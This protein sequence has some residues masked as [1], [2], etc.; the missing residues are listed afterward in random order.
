MKHYDGTVNTNMTVLY[1]PL[2]P[3]SDLPPEL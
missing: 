3:R 2:I 1:T